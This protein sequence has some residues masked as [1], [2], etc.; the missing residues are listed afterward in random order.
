ELQ[1]Y[2]ASEYP[3]SEFEF[4][5]LGRQNIFTRRL[6]V[7]LVI[8][9]NYYYDALFQK[10]KLYFK[11]DK[12]YLNDS[13]ASEGLNSPAI[14]HEYLKIRVVKKDYDNLFTFENQ[15]LFMI[16][17]PNDLNKKINN[18]INKIEFF[19]NPDKVIIKGAFLQDYKIILKGGAFE[20]GK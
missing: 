8:E 20:N 11:K 6:N 4:S 9:N 15:N 18:H 16:N 14:R 19:T 12:F 5:I 13:D 7:P 2:L 17:N 1:K 3:H 10:Q